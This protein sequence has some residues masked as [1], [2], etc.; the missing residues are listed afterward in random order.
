LAL[1]VET[2][3]VLSTSK[4]YKDTIQIGILLLLLYYLDQESVY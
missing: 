1:I 4:L 3:T 2:S